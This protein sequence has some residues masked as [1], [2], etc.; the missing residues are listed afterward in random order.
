MLAHHPIRTLPFHLTLQGMLW[1]NSNAGLQQQKLNSTQWKQNWQQ[2]AGVF[3]M[4]GALPQFDEAQLESAVQQELARRNANLVNGIFRYQTHPFHR[5]ESDA[6]TIWE[7]GTTRLL[8]FGHRLKKP[9]ATVFFIP[10]L[11]NRYYIL[12]L[13]PGR[14]LTEYLLAQNIRPLVIDWQDPGTEEAAFNCAD[15]VTK[16]LKPALAFAAMQGSTPLFLSGYCMG[17]LLA[18]ALAQITDVKLTGL[19]LLATPWNFH[20]HGFARIK[21][22]AEHSRKLEAMISAAPTLPGDVLQTL[23]YATNPWVFAR[24]FAAFGRPETPMD[25]DDAREFVAMESWVNDSVPMAAPVARECLI[26]WVQHNKPAAHEWKIGRDLVDPAILELP[27]LIAC[28]T[29]DTVVPPASAEALM[30]HLP[31]AKII[32]PISGHTGMV[33]SIHA[34]RELWHPLSAWIHAQM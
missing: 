28:P 2:F 31:D 5:P 19:S 21:L 20:T 9:K 4:M 10:S 15:Y 11:I 23:F 8:D 25:T 32:R 24:K 34:E 12:D 27:C 16:R 18:L 7:K 13:L 14:S 26:D 30:E 33:A 1:L 6:K 22:T 3:P 29:H 17:G